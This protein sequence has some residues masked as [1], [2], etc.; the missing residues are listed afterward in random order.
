MLKFGLKLRRRT[1][2]MRL[3]PRLGTGRDL[4]N[5]FIEVIAEHESLDSIVAVVADGMNTITGWKEGMIAHTERD[6]QRPILWLICQLHG[7]ELGLRHYFDQCD[8]LVG[9]VWFSK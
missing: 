1:I 4:A 5:T 6:L 7:N 9:L 2:R 3:R 8:G